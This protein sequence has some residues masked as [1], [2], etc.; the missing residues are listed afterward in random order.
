MKKDYRQIKAIFALG[1]KKG[2]DKEQLEEIAFSATNGRTSS[3]KSLTFNEANS[4]IVILGGKPFEKQ[5]IPRR[6]LNYRMQKT[7]VVALASERALQY[8]DILAKQKGI[9][10]E[11]LTRLCRR[12]LQSDRPK[13]AKG[14]SAVIEA[15]KSMIARERDKNRDADTEAA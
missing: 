15:L 4:I 6:T 14:A 8:I 11:G 13:T 2:L 12:M 7:G 1:I 9:S 5:P 10:H 3:L